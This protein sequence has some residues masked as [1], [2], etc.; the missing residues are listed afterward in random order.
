MLKV[1]LYF[2]RR[3]LSVRISLWAILFA[4]IVFIGTLTYIFHETR[5][6]VR[7]EA[8]SHATEILDNTVLRIEKILSRVEMSTAELS[9]FPQRH[10]DTPDSMI[11]YCRRM[12]ERNPDFFGCSVAFE[13]YCFKECGEYYSIYSWYEDGKLLTTQEG[14]DNYQYFYMDWYLLPKLLDKPCWSEPYLDLDPDTTYVKEMILSYSYPLRDGD[15]RFVG[16]MSTDISLSWLSQLISEVKPYPN[17]YSIMVGRGGTYLVHPDTTK[18]FYQTIFTPTLEHPDTTLTTLGRA[19]HKK[20]EGMRQMEI[21]GKDCYV[22]YKPLTGTDWSV[23]IVCSEDD[24]FGGYNRLANTVNIIVLVG[25][26]LLF[27][28]IGHIIN[29]E[30]KPLRQL[31]RQASIVASGHFDHVLPNNGRIDE[32]GH[33]SHSFDDMQHSLVN[34]ITELKETTASRAAIEN[35]LKV[36]SEIQMSMVPHEFPRRPDVDLYASMTP[37]KDVGGDLYDF[38]ITDNQL[39]FCI[40]DVSGK[41]VPASLFMSMTRNLFHHIAQQGCAPTEIAGLINNSLAQVNENMMFVTMFICRVD[42]CTG[43]LDFC[44]C[45]HNPPMLDGQFVQIKTANRPLGVFEDYEF[46]G[47]TIDDIRG[48]QFLLYT[49]GVN[50]AMNPSLEIYGDDRLMTFI[51]SVLNKSARE[52]ID[53]L[54]CDVDK[55]RAGAEPNDD[56]TL[57]CLKLSKS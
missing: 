19:M 3:K 56:V 15:G 7:E 38:F 8:I 14:N 25:L 36:A 51:S 40:G 5:Q 13:P 48:H 27:F 17:S 44:N 9:W 10:L 37:A 23:A 30:L 1:D 22:F 29:R 50:E 32:I 4:S 6:T 26:L 53:S 45:G 42:L 39:Y 11:V 18:L 41:G 34:Y 24:I 57:L 47:D 46:K 55:F 12:M 31:D 16:V 54:I 33:L 49:D 2:I 35:E 43:H 20:E 28:I 52:V 21:E